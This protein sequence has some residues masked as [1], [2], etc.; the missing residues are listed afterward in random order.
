LIK[1]L[2]QHRSDG[3]NAHRRTAAATTARTTV[4]TIASTAARTA[5]TAIIL[6]NRTTWDNGLKR[7]ESIK[8]LINGAIVDWQHQTI[9]ISASFGFQTY[10]PNDDLNQILIDADDTMYICKREKASNITA[11]IAQF[12]CQASA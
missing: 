3:N 11:K 8:G 1:R 6:L 2:V 12:S 7:A 10:G 9:T 4:S 5:T